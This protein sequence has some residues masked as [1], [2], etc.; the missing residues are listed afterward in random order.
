LPRISRTSPCTSYVRSL[1]CRDFPTRH[2][3][4]LLFSAATG[5]SP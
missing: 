2:C 1:P 3:A 5:G 4:P